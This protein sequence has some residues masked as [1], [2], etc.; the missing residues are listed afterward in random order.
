MV[1]RRSAPGEADQK[2]SP[3]Y[4]PMLPKPGRAVFGSKEHARGR[5]IDGPPQDSPPPKAVER[6]AGWRRTVDPSPFYTPRG[7][8][9]PA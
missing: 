1:P 6:S 8:A 3:T 2:C 9:I 5:G 7:A 4:L